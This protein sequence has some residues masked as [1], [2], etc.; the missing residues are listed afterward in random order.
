MLCSRDMSR[1]KDAALEDFVGRAV[2]FGLE[3][4]AL[5]R[6]LPVVNATE[7]AA[8]EMLEEALKANARR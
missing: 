3:R 4:D 1:R 2:A 6:F 7:L 5:A 8:E